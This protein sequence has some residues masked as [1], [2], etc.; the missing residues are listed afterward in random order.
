MKRTLCTFIL[1]L[2]WALVLALAAPPAAAD[3]VT[4]MGAD[5]LRL[6]EKPCPVTM[7][8]YLP[9]EI[10]GRF[11]EAVAIM[12]GKTYMGCWTIRGD[13]Q[14][15]LRYEDGDGGLVPLTSFKDEP[16]T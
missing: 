8:K 11:L 4:R 13:G 15:F 1:A 2:V 3:L 10:I 7:S 12:D 6:T 5:T 16:S 9:A 14:V